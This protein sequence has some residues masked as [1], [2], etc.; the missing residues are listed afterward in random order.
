MRLIFEKSFPDDISGPFLAMDN[1][2]AASRILS[3]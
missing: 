1:P 2:L 3:I